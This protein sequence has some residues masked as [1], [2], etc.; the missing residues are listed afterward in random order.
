MYN[1]SGRA[2]SIAI[3]TAV[4]CLVLTAL[5]LVAWR[6]AMVLVEPLHGTSPRADGVLM[7][8]VAR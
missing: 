3:G 7:G 1:P 5:G 8:E 6:L 2:D 4:G